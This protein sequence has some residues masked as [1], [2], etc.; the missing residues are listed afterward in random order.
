MLNRLTVWYGEQY[1]VNLGTAENL[2]YKVAAMK[3]AVAELGEYKT[4][5]VDASF[6]EWPDQVRFEPF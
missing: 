1:E 3:A 5:L 6:S 2:V 4:G